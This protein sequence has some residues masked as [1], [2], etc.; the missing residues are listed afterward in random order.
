SDGHLAHIAKLR[1]RD[2]RSV[3][4][5]EAGTTYA[6][7]DEQEAPLRLANRAHRTIEAKRH[8]R[9]SLGVRRNGNEGLPVEIPRDDVVRHTAM[10]LACLSV[11]AIILAMQRHLPRV[12]MKPPPFREHALYVLPRVSV[13]EPIHER[14]DRREPPHLDRI[15]LKERASVS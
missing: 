10:V 3:D 14:S 11:V 2:F 6:A 7:R 12:R 13:V 9:A 1:R 5:R 8:P 15:A 4:S